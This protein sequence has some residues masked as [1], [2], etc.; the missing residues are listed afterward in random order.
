MPFCQLMQ[1]RNQLITVP[2]PGSSTG[3]TKG[4]VVLGAY[5]ASVARTEIG[6]ALEKST[7][8]EGRLGPTDIQ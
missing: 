5:L 4:F 7:A 6:C 3:A 8:R 2:F 1:F